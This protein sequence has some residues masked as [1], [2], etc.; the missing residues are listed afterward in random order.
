MYNLGP[1]KNRHQ[2]IINHIKDL[3][4]EKQD[5]KQALNRMVVEILCCESKY[6]RDAFIGKSR[7]RTVQ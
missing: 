5:A 1:S 3:L 7:H 2:D 6:F 4:E